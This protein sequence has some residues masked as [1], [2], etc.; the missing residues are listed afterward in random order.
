MMMFSVLINPTGAK[1]APPGFG[2][3]GD[4]GSDEYRADDWRGGAYWETTFVWDELLVRYR[5]LD[6]GP[7]GTRSWPRRTGYEY[8]WALSGATANDV[9]TS[10][11]HTGL[12][13]QVAEGKVQNVFFLIGP[14]DFAIW[15]GTYAAVYNGM[16]QAQIDAKVNGIISDMALAIDTVLA[17]GPVN[18]VVAN[19]RDRGNSD[20]FQALYPDPARRAVVTAAF[21]AVNAGIENIVATRNIKMFDMIN[22]PLP[23]YISIDANGNIVI[24]GEVINT[25]IDSDDPHY[26]ILS[27]GDHIGTVGEGIKANA[28]LDEFNTFGLEIPKFTA[29]EILNNAGIFPAVP[30]TT[31]P[32]VSVT[33]PANNA[34]TTGVVS[35]TANATD[36][37]GV[38]GVQ[39]M[40]NGVNLG[41]EDATAPYSVSWNTSSVSNGSH[42]LVAIARDLAGNQATSSTVVV[43]VSNPVPDTT[44]PS[45]SIDS[46]ANGSNV[47]GTIA[48]N[49]TATDNVSV[50]GVQF[51]L[52][53]A[54]LG[55]EDTSSP[56]SVNWNT[57][58]ASLGT[59]TLTATA[60]DAAGN[61]ITS[62][63]TVIVVDTTLPTVTL[64]SPANNATVT[65][66]ITVRASA[67]D[68]RG[69]AGVQFKLDGVNLGAEDT[70]SAYTRS[71][72]TTGTPNGTH[73]LTATARDTSGNLTT[74]SSTTVT[75]SNPVPDTTAPAV[76]VTAPTNGSVVTGTVSLT[77]NAT[78]NV[79]VVGVQFRVN[80]TN[81]GSEDTTAP[82]SVSWNTSSIAIGSHTITAIARDAAGNQATSSTITVNVSNPVPD[83]TLPTVSMTAPTNGS[84]VSGTVSI[85]ANAADNIGVVGVQFR[86]NGVN[87]GA[88]DASA[89][90]SASWNTSSLANGQY[91]I[92]AIARDAAGNTTESS[93]I[94]LT[95]NNVAS[96]TSYTSTVYTVR[97]G[98]YVGGNAASFASD[99]NNYFE[100]R[101]STSGITRT[102]NLDT[103]VEN[104]TGTI[105]RLDYSVRLKS[106]TSSTTVRIYAYNFTTGALVQVGSATVGT[107]EVTINGSLTS[108]LSQY[109]DSSNQIGIIISSSKL[110]STHNLSVDFARLTVTP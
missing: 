12:A 87:L 69:V 41:V 8:N 23:E 46:P 103:A 10:G 73:V 27:D 14:N 67:S 108:N 71:W 74:T 98:S 84:T 44:A 40:L 29:L 75:V 51:R 4:S 79:G 32:S 82:Y 91:T 106:S 35:V 39:F 95:V 43:N 80:G 92:V 9:I 57:S 105:S 15:N 55:S 89:P 107:S 77:A 26:L 65:G 85:T 56:Y 38:V 3:M 33:A 54:S 50:V 102:M 53:G 62:T 18:F 30:D 86:V 76:S 109:R 48:V 1:A 25:S 31:V 20:R 97:T 94:T 93:P 16:T 64:T 22:A 70:T 60:R 99:D 7:W 2:I 110:L 37:V 90:Y 47:S 52:D 49:A 17:A 88:E 100:A 36:N 72:N 5:G 21:N 34:T 28:I 24:L 11:Q 96:T 6:F 81:V 63:S 19:V 45:V 58:S 83:T 104:V 61:Q 68:N 101:S 13:Q 59:H 78:D 42:S 66:T